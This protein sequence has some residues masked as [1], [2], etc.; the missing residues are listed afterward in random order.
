MSRC[1]LWRQITIGPGTGADY[2][3]LACFHYRSHRVG[4]AVRILAARYEPPGAEAVLAG[5]LVESLPPLSCRLREAALPGR[6]G[7][8]DAAGA[9]S[10]RVLLAARLNAEMRTLS[11]VVIHPTFRSIGLA[12][13]LV[14]AAL[15]TAETPYIEAFA[16]MGRVHPFFRAAGMREYDRPPDAAAVRLA[17]A[18][19]HAG[20]R[21]IDLADASRVPEGALLRRE[22]QRFTRLKSDDF[23]A[24]VRAARGRLLSQPVYYLWRA[25][26]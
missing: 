5:V 16:A 7:G 8:G 4:A 17:A 9:S 2:A 1:T 6:Y 14:R 18:L 23:A 22:L 20:L 15:A 13:A 12:V 21:P 10:S 26:F 19:A 3:A 24:L 25:D 11:R